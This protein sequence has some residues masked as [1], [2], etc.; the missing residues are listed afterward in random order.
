MG[1]ALNNNTWNT[2]A[3][4]LP[5]IVSTGGASKLAGYGGVSSK[6]KI[7]TMSTD[8]LLTEQYANLLELTHSRSRREAVDAAIAYTDATNNAALM[9]DWPFDNQ[10]PGPG[11]RR[12]NLVDQLNQVARAIVARG[13]DG[14]NQQRQ[15]FFV[16]RGGFDNH[17]NLI[18]NHS[19]S[20]PEVS[21]ALYHFTEEL[22]AQGLLDCVTTFTM[23]DFGRTQVPNDNSGTDHAWASNQLAI[24][25]T[26]LNGGQ[27][28]GTY[29]D[30]SNPADFN[31]N[32][33]QYTTDRRGRMI[34]GASVD[35]YV[36]E[37]VQWFGVSETDLPLILPNI[38]NFPDSLGL[39]S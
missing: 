35:E 3:R 27:V 37:L 25:G 38:G 6:D 4:T 12:N 30:M 1:I 29:P 17:K 19:G 26:Q 11:E 13:P 39:M 23:S 28:H 2:G 9:T 10:P 36:K 15:I 5:Y 7:L 18:S 20:M 31:T 8:M 32:G 22:R 24:G 34:P 16:F 14:L 33:G 21:E